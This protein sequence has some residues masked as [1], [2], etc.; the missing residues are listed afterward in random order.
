M[1]P[2]VTIRRRDKAQSGDLERGLL[3]VSG[4]DLALTWTV[5][6]MRKRNTN[7]LSY[8]NYHIRTAEWWTEIHPDHDRL[9][10]WTQHAATWY[11]HQAKASDVLSTAE[12]LV[13]PALFE[14]TRIK[15]TDTLTAV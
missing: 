5:E 3:I 15:S 6:C 12:F 10:A 8:E 1:H 4:W 9:M 13:L 2:C 11:M 7:M 14:S